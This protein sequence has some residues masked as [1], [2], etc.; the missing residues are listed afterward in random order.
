M[1]EFTAPIFRLKFACRLK[2]EF[3]VAYNQPR[4][5]KALKYENYIL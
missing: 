4:R 3:E 1:T 2:P 5:C